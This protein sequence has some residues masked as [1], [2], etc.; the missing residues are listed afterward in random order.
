MEPDLCR[1]P[2]PEY[3]LDLF[4]GWARLSGKHAQHDDF[5]YPVVNIPNTSST[6]NK[7]NHNFPL[8]SFKPYPNLPAMQCVSHVLVFMM[9]LQKCCIRTNPVYVLVLTLYP[10]QRSGSIERSRTSEF[11]GQG[12]SVGN[13]T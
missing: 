1:R 7:V 12:L 5:P 8:L 4:F 10:I 13:S 11:G 2:G 3:I 9:S 6:L